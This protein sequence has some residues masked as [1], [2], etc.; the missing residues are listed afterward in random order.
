MHY[1]STKLC[2]PF[3]AAASQ[4]SNDYPGGPLYLPDAVGDT[5]EWL[6]SEAFAPVGTFRNASCVGKTFFYYRFAEWHPSVITDYFSTSH[7]AATNAPG[8]VS[9]LT[10]IT[11]WGHT[12]ADIAAIADWLQHHPPF[13]APLH[14]LGLLDYN[15]TIRWGYLW[16]TWWRPPSPWQDFPLVSSAI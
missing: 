9:N 15:S 1:R 12:P 16:S 3:T 11:R 6:G 13:L 7:V 4:W 2:R 10:F 14:A 8:N 5:L